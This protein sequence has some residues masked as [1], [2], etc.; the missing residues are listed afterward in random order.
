MLR[1]RCS[2]RLK[3][4]SRAAPSGARCTHVDHRYSGPRRALHPGRY[5]ALHRRPARPEPALAAR[6]GRPHRRSCLARR[7][8]AAARPV[9]PAGQ[10][11]HGARPDSARHRRRGR[12]HAGRLRTGAARRRRGPGRRLVLP[13]RGGARSAGGL[14]DRR[15][16][17]GRPD[18]R[19]PDGHGDHGRGAPGGRGR[20]GAG[21][22]GG[23]RRRATGPGRAAGRP[24][25]GSG[26]G[27]GTAREGRELDA[28][29]AARLVVGR[30]GRVGADAV[31]R[32]VGGHLP[33]G[34]AVAGPGSA[35]A[36][37]H[38]RRV[39]R[40]RGDL[41]GPGRG[42]GGGARGT[43]RHR[44]AAGRPARRRARRH[45][46]VPGRRGRRRPHPGRDQRLPLRRGR[47]RRQAARDRHRKAAAWRAGGCGRDRAAR[48]GPRRRRADHA[49]RPG[50]GADRLLRH[51]LRAVHGGRGA[52][53]HGRHP[54]ARRA[55]LR[56][57]AGDP[58][59]LRLGAARGGR[60][61]RAGRA[62][63]TNG[64]PAPGAD[65][66]HVGSAHL[67]GRRAAPPGR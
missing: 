29:R 39:R 32:R 66:P 58:G 8:G 26:A 64:R 7:L 15:G 1:H 9:R 43:G 30:P 33:T 24:R 40:H 38:R 14:P 42:H 3:S 2:G 18:R 11:V 47:A 6:P 53:D 34:R 10:G 23:A 63:R 13:G 19:W 28:V 16:V 56:G 48:A 52:A 67:S 59:L 22:P 5:R 62:G 65:R 46:P 60:G 41:P 37:D 21:R 20:H 17:R 45:R 57:R 27:R 35:A 54:G 49:G 25:R 51:R 31:V 36:T 55:G 44:R 61:R 4:P 12:L 50:G